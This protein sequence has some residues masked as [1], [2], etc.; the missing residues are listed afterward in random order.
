MDKTHK[1]VLVKYRKRKA[2]IDEDIAPLILE[3]WKRRIT[4]TNS[5]QDNV[6]KGYVWIEFFS[7]FDAAEFIRILQI[8]H[9]PDL[10]GLFNRVYQRWWYEGGSIRRKWRYRAHP[11]QIGEITFFAVSIRFPRSDLPFVLSRFRK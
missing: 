10:N 6:P 9:T 3:C 8:K 5:C 1:T 4:T 11:T 2:R 7:S